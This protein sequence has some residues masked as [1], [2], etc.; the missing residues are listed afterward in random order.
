MIEAIEHVRSVTA[1]V[2]LDA[3]EADWQKRWLV[4]RGVEILSEPAA[5]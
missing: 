2:P 1:G 3:F 4:G 5:T